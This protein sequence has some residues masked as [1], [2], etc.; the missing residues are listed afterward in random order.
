MPRKKR[1]RPL[2]CNGLELSDNDDDDDS[3]RD[4]DDDARD[5]ND[6]SSK[7]KQ[8]AATEV[9]R[10][11]WLTTNE[12]NTDDDLANDDWAPMV[13]SSDGGGDCCDTDGGNA[14]DLDMRCNADDEAGQET[15][16][17]SNAL[18]NPL[19]SYLK[20]FLICSDDKG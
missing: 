2:V 3:D 14:T 13:E 1:K 15:C 16:E 7:A 8:M 6:D 9:T 11:I 18:H 4:D 17:G 20:S 19:K 5:D 12:C 10:A